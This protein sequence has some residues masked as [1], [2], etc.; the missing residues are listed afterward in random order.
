MLIR[1]VFEKRR[2][3]VSSCISLR[4]TENRFAPAGLGAKR[5][6]STAIASIC[7]D[8][9]WDAKRFECSKTCATRH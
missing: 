8:I 4:Y 2:F 7:N 6:N 3:L 5:S 9:P 1:G